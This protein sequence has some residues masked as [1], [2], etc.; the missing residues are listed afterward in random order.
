DAFSPGA[1]PEQ[2]TFTG[3]MVLDAFSTLTMELGGL[4]P[5]T[6][7]DK[8]VVTGLLTL[9]GGVLDVLFWNGFAPS[10]GNAF[11]LLE[12]GTR[13]GMFGSIALPALS[14]GLAWD[15]SHLYVDG[16]IAVAA[17]PE[18]G[19]YAMMLVGLAVL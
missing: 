12:W 15:T 13:N 18:P 3:N 5:G 2:V 1:S 8:L 17:V 10:A 9:N 11:D 14:P 19:T 4:V 16:S 7:H 6:E